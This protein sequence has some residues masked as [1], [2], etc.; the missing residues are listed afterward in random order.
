MNLIVEG[1]DYKIQK[2]AK[3]H[4]YLIGIVLAVSSSLFIGSS[5]ILK[6]VSLLKLS[7]SSS[8]RAGAGG[9]GY[10]KDWIWW[11][12]FL[13]SKFFTYSVGSK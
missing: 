7:R 12:G 13:S 4:N 1:P 2:N 5:Y 3:D 6:K 10:L 9:F 11:M 8:L